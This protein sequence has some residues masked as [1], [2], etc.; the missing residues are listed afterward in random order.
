MIEF[1][2]K[3]DYTVKYYFEFRPVFNM[4]FVQSVYVS[5][6]WIEKKFGSYK[7]A[8]VFCRRSKRLILIY[9]YGGMVPNKPQ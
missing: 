8:E 3:N 4:E 5:H 9:N 2:N 7:Y 1:K 6:L